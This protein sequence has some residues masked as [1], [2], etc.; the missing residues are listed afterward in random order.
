MIIS[1]LTNE[2]LAT[3]YGG[4]NFISLFRRITA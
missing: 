2:V 3:A 1:I 4:A